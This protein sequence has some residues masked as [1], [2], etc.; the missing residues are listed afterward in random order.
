MKISERIISITLIIIMVIIP[1]FL[2]IALIIAFLTAKNMANPKKYNKED[3]L[4]EDIEGVG[5]LFDLK[6]YIQ[7]GPLKTETLITIENKKIEYEIWGKE[8][9][10]KYVILVHGMYNTRERMYKYAKVWNDAGYNAIAF[11]G[12]GWGTNAILGRCT[13]GYKEP[14]VIQEIY[15][16]VVEKYKTRNIGLHGES[17]GGATVFNWIKKYRKF[18]PVQF[19]VAEAGYMDFRKP[20]LLGIKKYKVPTVMAIAIY[21][22]V[23][24]WLLTFGIN[25]W[26]VNVKQKHI[27][28]WFDI[29]MLLIHSKTDSV[30]PWEEY[31]RIKEMLQKSKVDFETLELEEGNHVRILTNKDIQKE[32]VEEINKFIKEVENEK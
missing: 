1:I 23:K 24:L 30:V 18:T 20:A 21:P 25:L 26:K 14:D 31:E 8:T 2:I 4:K 29:P 10:K 22:L 5:K 12:R 28:Q 13:M 16:D 27:K 19:V 9:N 17:M 7:K 11:D 32:W 6:K 15:L 3:I